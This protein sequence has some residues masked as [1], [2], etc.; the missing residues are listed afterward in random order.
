MYLS[1]Y[2]YFIATTGT[3]PRLLAIEV[4]AAAPLSITA[5]GSY[6]ITPTVKVA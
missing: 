2:G 3:T 1:V 5:G 6:S 4:D